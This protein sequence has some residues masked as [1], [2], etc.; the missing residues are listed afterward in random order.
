L[1]PTA[2][3]DNASLVYMSHLHHRKPFFDYLRNIFYTL[4]FPTEVVSEYKLGAEKEPH[5]EIIIEK[6]K[7]EAGFW[8]FCTSYDS[9]V[10]AMIQN[11]E[12]ID[13]GEAESYAQ[14]RKVNA[15]FIISDDNN[16]TKAINKLDPYIKVYSTLHI[17]C[18]LDVAGYLPDWQ[19]RI[20]DLHQLRPFKSAQLRAAYLTI[21]EK[22]GLAITGKEVSNK[23]SLSKIL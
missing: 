10:M 23:C 19:N 2:V 14:F 16:F 4:Y 12:G 11:Q 3:I 18:W 7:P 22:F 21:I 13:K 15:H 9:F 8:R 5:R 17:I 1:R 6:I 20:K